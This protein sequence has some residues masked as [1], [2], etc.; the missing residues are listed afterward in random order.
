MNA[1]NDH[2]HRP[3]PHPFVYKPRTEEQW[4]RHLYDSRSSAVEP[5]HR[6]DLIAAT[7]NRV[8][9]S[10]YITVCP[11]YRVTVRQLQDMFK[12][13]I[14]ETGARVGYIVGYEREPS[15]HLH[16]CIVSRDE[17]TA[18]VIECIWRR[19]VGTNPTNVE[20]QKFNAF[21]RG[22]SKYPPSRSTVSYCVKVV[23]KPFEQSDD[24]DI[25]A[26]ILT[27]CPRDNTRSRR[28]KRR[29]HLQ[30]SAP[31]PLARAQGPSI[32][33]RFLAQRGKPRPQSQPSPQS[34]PGG[35]I[36]DRFLG[37]LNRRVTTPP[38]H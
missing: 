4:A 3:H 27:F 36:R 7:Y 38:E 8:P 32:R 24:W 10:F 30:P 21:E 13:F 37:A 17:R 26:N 14:E 19:M 2:V 5:Y 6:S 18:T 20:V 16:A 15:P 22:D 25:S 28:A 34:Q 23:D 35:S 12:R 11:N 33:D 31:G 29:K 9:F 1:A